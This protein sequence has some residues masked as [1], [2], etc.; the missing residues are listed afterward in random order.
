M[1]SR[2]F[3]GMVLAAGAASRSCRLWRRRDILVKAAINAV[4]IT[5][6]KKSAV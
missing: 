2:V 4:A 1:T 6:A 3:Q 5:T